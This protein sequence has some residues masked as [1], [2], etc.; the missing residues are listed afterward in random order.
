MTSAPD[1]GPPLHLAGNCG[2]VTEQVTAQPTAVA[3][4]IPPEL[5]A[6][7]LLPRSVYPCESPTG[8]YGTWIPHPGYPLKRGRR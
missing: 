4:Q 5:E 3:G 2:S 1:A 7:R 6:R 8:F